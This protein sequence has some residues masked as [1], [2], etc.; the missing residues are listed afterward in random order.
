MTPIKDLTSE[1]A[2]TPKDAKKLEGVFASMVALKSSVAPSPVFRNTLAERVIALSAMQVSAFYILKRQNNL[3]AWVFASLVLVGGSLYV[4][5][6]TLF[7]NPI[8]G[9][10][11]TISTPVEQKPTNTPQSSW[12]DD[13]PVPI[14]EEDVLDDSIVPKEDIILETPQD[15][16]QDNL[17]ED[18][19]QW[20][21]E[22]NS[23][24]ILES[25]IEDTTVSPALDSDEISEIPEDISLEKESSPESER[26]PEQDI[27]EEADDSVEKSDSQD[28]QDILPDQKIEPLLEWDQSKSTDSR[29]DSKEALVDIFTRYCS[30][31]GWIY[32]I[33]D[34]IDIHSCTLWGNTCSLNDFKE[35][36]SCSIFEEPE[37]EQETGS[38]TVSDTAEE[39]ST[40]Q[41]QQVEQNTSSSPQTDEANQTPSS[42]S[43]SE[44]PQQQPEQQQQP[45]QQDPD[46]QG[47]EGTWQVS[48]SENHSSS[49]KRSTPPTSSGS[50]QD[51]RGQSAEKTKQKNKQKSNNRRSNSE[52]F[53][54]K[55]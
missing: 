55:P 14:S 44:Q 47:D 54:T 4:A 43:W 45:Q 17:E 21:P 38:G 52:T 30:D 19:E 13:T 51:N 36:E 2:T 8:T 49:E 23:S 3:F 48:E 29:Q 46:F 33:F 12:S 28:E 31:Q 24:D 22:G 42:S 7:T 20:D 6:D 16:L 18:I 53:E 15:A 37:S 50:I 35:T 32:S 11:K 27:T 9:E 34:G 26:L 39:S 40:E 5:S 41:E 1:F 10:Q 25:N